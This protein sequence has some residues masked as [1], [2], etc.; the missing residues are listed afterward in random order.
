MTDRA[1]RSSV[2]LWRGQSQFAH[3]TVAT[4]SLYVKLQFGGSWPE[5]H[6]VLVCGGPEQTSALARYWW[7]V[8]ST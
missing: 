1:E 3:N 7:P 2:D 8:R 6:N 5:R 4:E